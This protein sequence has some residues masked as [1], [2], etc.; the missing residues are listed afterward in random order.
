MLRDYKQVFIKPVKLELIKMR[1][2]GPQLPLFTVEKKA[3][4][5]MGS[6]TGILCASS[7]NWHGE[8]TINP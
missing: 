1:K 7:E 8:I 2:I 5:H 4:W 6:L 3:Q